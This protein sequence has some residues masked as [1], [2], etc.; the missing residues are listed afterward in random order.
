VSVARIGKQR[1][2]DV[3]ATDVI[4]P[5]VTEIRTRTSESS[6]FSGGLALGRVD[7]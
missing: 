4:S 7:A 6:I 2:A 3:R 1:E 5:D